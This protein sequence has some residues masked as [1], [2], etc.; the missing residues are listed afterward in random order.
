M[1]GTSTIDWSGFSF[2]S[3]A[4]KGW[5]MLLLR[6]GKTTAPYVFFHPGGNMDS[7]QLR[8]LSG[9]IVAIGLLYDANEENSR[10]LDFLGASGS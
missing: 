7:Q 6:Y 3:T 8:N 2:G 4:E 9:S 10:F 1:K 5:Y